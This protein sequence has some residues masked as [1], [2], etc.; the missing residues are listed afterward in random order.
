MILSKKALAWIFMVFGTAFMVVSCGGDDEGMMS[1]D[2]PIASFQFEIS[3]SN[4][5]EVTFTNF[6]QNASSYTWDFGDG[7]VSNEENPTHTYSE[8]GDYVVELTATNTEGS[9]SVTKKHYYHRS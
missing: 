7:N 2:P 6:S 9:R 4:F 5:L 8:G 1:N 3:T